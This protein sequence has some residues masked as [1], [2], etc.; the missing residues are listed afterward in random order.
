MKSLQI[1]KVLS[2]QLASRN[3]LLR[4]PEPDP[5]ILVSRPSSSIYIGKTLFCRVPFFWDPRKLVNPHLC[6]VGITGSGKS[7]FIKTFIT[8]ARLV[9]GAS[10]LILDW[11]GEYSSWV[12]AAGGRVVDFGRNGVNMMD[13]GGQKPHVRAR[14]VISALCMLTDLG[15]Y[16]EQ[17]RITEDAMLECYRRWKSPTLKHLLFLLGKRQKQSEAHRICARRIRNL[18]LASGESFCSSKL[19]ISSISEG[20]VCIDLHSLPTEE[21]RSLA[22]LTILQFLKESMRLSS[23]SENPFPRLFVVV[24]EAWKIASDERSDVISIV[25]EGRKYGFSIIVASQNPSDVHKSIFSNSGTT[26]CFRL[27]LDSERA[28]VRSSLSYSQN[29]EELSHS[30]GVGQAL[31]HIET[32]TPA[33][34]SRDFILK[35]DGEPL[36]EFCRLR[37]GGMDISLERSELLRQLHLFGLSEKQAAIVLAKF[38]KSSLSMEASEFVRILEGFGFARPTI[39][40]LLRELGAGEKQLLEVFSNLRMAGSEGKVEFELSEKEESRKEGKK[41]GANAARKQ[42]SP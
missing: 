10:A 36:A 34:C 33:Q 2:G 17:I 27:T 19:K 24:D 37:G 14:Q 41:R 35:V 42:N 13:L 39:I 23:Y 6:V 32:A 29:Y 15:N 7:Y 8:R 26:I 18:L 16:P 12:W 28:Y 40:S 1:N 25:R 22:G 21:Q 31:V 3:I 4:P 20:L 30:L 11:A 9:L 5:K 38:E